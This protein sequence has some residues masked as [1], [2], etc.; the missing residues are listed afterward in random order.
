MKIFYVAVALPM[1]LLRSCG[2]LPAN[3]DKI[4]QAEIETV[5]TT[6]QQTP[7][8]LTGIQQ[9]KTL[10]AA[11]YD[12]WF[13]LN[14]E[15]AEP[16]AVVVDSI[17]PLLKGI[18]FKLFMGTWCADSKREVPYFFKVLDMTD[19]DQMDIEIITMTHDK[20]TPENF[21][22]DLNITNVPTIIF[23]RNGK[24]INR[25]VEYPINT[26]EEDMLDILSGREYH[27]AYDW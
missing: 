4:V 13:R 6:E 5:D 9:R 11:P 15:E 18:K 1:I 20:T 24:E 25:I 14:Y 3:A 21:E 16:D 12:E 19:Y 22:K 10:E 23:Y 27:N 26:M 17:K 7:P 8:V 2:E